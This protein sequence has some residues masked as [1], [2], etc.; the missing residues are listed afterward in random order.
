[1]L[2]TVD[3]ETSSPL[4]LTCS[5]CQPGVVVMNPTKDLSIADS[6]RA[7]VVSQYRL[8]L[9]EGIREATKLWARLL[10]ESLPGKLLGNKLPGKSL[11]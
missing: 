9:N 10:E 5:L 6:G 1:M 11:D 2:C 8:P 4:I 3:T 7:A